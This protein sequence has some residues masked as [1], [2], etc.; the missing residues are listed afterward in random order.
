MGPAPMGTVG[1]VFPKQEEEITAAG[2]PILSLRGHNSR[3][4]RAS[5]STISRMASLTPS[6]QDPT[7][8][9]ARP[10]PT[11]LVLSQASGKL[12]LPHR[13]H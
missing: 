7:T 1:P 3:L 2:C 10:S 5:D 9:G 12:P 13:T 6:P 8:P 4:Q 11:S